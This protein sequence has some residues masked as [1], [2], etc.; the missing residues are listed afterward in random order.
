MSQLSHFSFKLLRDSR[1]ETMPECIMWFLALIGC[2]TLMRCCLR[3]LTNM[4]VSELMKH[5][6]I[7][8][9]KGHENNKVYTILSKSEVVHT[10]NCSAL[11]AARQTPQLRTHCSH[12]ADIERRS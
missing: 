11:R 8:G 6:E 12:C 1:I 3:G 10:Q 9:H 2:L 4:V 5:K 7:E